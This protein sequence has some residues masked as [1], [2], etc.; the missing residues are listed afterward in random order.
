MTK[1]EIFQA[2]NGAIEFKGDSNHETVWA[3]LEQIA[4]LFK[5][6]KSGISRHIKNIYK[7]E[8][9]EQEAVVAI[10]ATTASD[11]KTYQVEYYN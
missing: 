2:E 6:D 9:L 11:G 10:I 3:S 8:E 4:Q 1:I 7:S 5:R